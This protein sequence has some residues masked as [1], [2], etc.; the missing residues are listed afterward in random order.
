MGIPSLRVL[1]KVELEESEWVKLRYEQMNM[2]SE[3]RLVV[4]FQN[5]SH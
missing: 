1:T 5:Q 4:I 2:I 3:K